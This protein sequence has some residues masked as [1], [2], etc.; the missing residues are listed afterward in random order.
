MY[1]H[2]ISRAHKI[3]RMHSNKKNTRHTSTVQKCYTNTEAQKELILKNYFNDDR[4]RIKT[5]IDI[6]TVFYTGTM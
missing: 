1:Y 6:L 2:Y 4:S 5:I 3:D